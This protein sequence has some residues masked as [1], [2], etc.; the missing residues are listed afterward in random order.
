MSLPSPPPDLDLSES[1]VSEIQGVLLSTWILALIAVVLRVVARRLKGNPLWIEDYLVFVSL[2]AAAVHVFVSVCYMA[3]NGTGKHVWAAPPEATKVW[4]TGLF[5]SEIVYTITLATVKWSTLAFYWRIFSANQSIRIPIWTLGGIVLVW[6]IAVLIVTVLQCQPL[7]SFWLRFDPVNPPAPGSFTCDVDLNAFFNGNS[8]PNI[9]TD[10]LVVLLPAPYI[11]RLQLSAV[12][13][14]ALTGIF[15]LGIFVTVISVVRLVNILDVD[16]AS[17][18]VTW[19]FVGAVVWTNT[20]ANGAIV[21]CCLPSLRPVLSLA[22]RGTVRSTAP[23]A[24]RKMGSSTGGEAGR[25]ARGLSASRL[26]GASRHASASKMGGARVDDERPFARLEDQVSCAYTDDAG[27]GHE[28]A[29]LPRGR[30]IL[31]TKTLK[32]ESSVNSVDDGP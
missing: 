31:V 26:A 7:S 3:P 5:I 29:D 17:P 11:L 27:S 32:L 22:L 25:H 13:R 20:E 1:R 6:A 14:V 8:I 2:I 23:S 12:H 21:A 4:A 30:S 28:L 16:L 15:S 10:A 18:D 24:E 19:N 9:V